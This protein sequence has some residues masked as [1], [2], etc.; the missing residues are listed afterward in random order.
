M[1]SQTT[2]H[3]T[4]MHTVSMAFFFQAHGKTA[5]IGDQAWKEVRLGSIIPIHYFFSQLF[6]SHGRE[7]EAGYSRMSL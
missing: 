7:A 5:G 6:L 3:A 1:G 4:R 2:T